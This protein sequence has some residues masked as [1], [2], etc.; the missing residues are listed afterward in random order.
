[1]KWPP[2]RVLS[3]F[4]KGLQK[5]WLFLPFFLLIFPFLNSCIIIFLPSCIILFVLELS[6]LTPN[7]LP[8]SPPNITTLAW[9]ISSLTTTECLSSPIQSYWITTGSNVMVI[10]ALCYPWWPLL[11]PLEAFHPGRHMTSWRCLQNS[12]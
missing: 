1:M 11:I 12:R 2:Q 4:C 7:T 8:H 10:P 3:S 6:N 5:Y 9:H